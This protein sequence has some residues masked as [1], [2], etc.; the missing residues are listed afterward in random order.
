[1][2]LPLLIVLLI[3]LGVVSCSDRASLEQKVRQT[4]SKTEGRFAVAFKDLSNGETLYINADSIFHA[5]STMKTPV[6]AELFRQAGEGRFSLDD[7]LVIKNG[8][9]SIVDGSPFSLSRSDDSD[10]LIYD[11][12]GA[13][14]SIRKLMTDMIIVSSNLATNML[15][16]LV[17]A[18]KVDSLLKRIGAPNMHVLRGVED[19][20]AFEAGLNN[21]TSARGQLL[22]YEQIATNKLVNESSSLEMIQILSDQRF[23]EIIPAQLPSD[24]IVAHKTGSI[25][26]VQHDGGIVMLPDGRKYILVLLSSNLQDRDQ[27]IQVLADVS[28][29][30]Y[31]HV[32][33]SEKR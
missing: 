16:D 30:I 4:L 10:T 32:I 20:K 14:E 25:T 23:G 19:T 9:T 5:A 6:M 13:K 18:K 24:V 31:Q 33:Q 7:S 2:K 12:V 17:G 15:I 29:I 28:E 8:F 11:R 1:M 22:L 3:S 27:G 21:T 26:G